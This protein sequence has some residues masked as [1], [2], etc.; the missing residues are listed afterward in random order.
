MGIGGGVRLGTGGGAADKAKEYLAVRRGKALHVFHRDVNGAVTQVDKVVLFPVIP[1]SRC[2][3]RVK[4]LLPGTV[5]LHADE[6]P[7]DRAKFSHRFNRP[8]PLFG[9]ASVKRTEG[10]DFGT[11]YLRREKG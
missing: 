4:G 2:Q 8:S 7:E 11:V 6:F 1:S 10:D 9:I 3:Q 5:R